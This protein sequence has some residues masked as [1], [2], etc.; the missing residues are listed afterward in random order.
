MGEI[1]AEDGRGIGGRIVRLAA[2]SVGAEVGHN[3]PEPCRRQP[4]RMA[5]LDPV[6]PRV[7]EEAVDEHH[8]PP[9][10]RFMVRKVDAVGRGPVVRGMGHGLAM[11]G[12][13]DENKR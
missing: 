13:R 12:V 4:R 8:R 7:R 2:L 9:L 11:M 3:H 6:Q 10:A 5:E 1:A